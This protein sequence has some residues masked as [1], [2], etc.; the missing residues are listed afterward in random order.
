M[1]STLS[2]RL[3]L[4]GGC[5]EKEAGIASTTLLGVPRLLNSL[6]NGRMNEK[7]LETTIGFGVGG[8][9][10]GMEECKGTGNCCTAYVFRLRAS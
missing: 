10:Q 1:E 5:V 8:G 7:K 2:K 6:G 9:W 3:L 4:S